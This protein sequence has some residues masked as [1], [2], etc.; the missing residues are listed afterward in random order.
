MRCAC[1][2]ETDGEEEAVV[3]AVQ[4][5]GRRRHNMEASREQV[6]AMAVAGADD[7][8]VDDQR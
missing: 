4:E 5:H 6:M 8:A 7:Q 2:W 3:E 1:G